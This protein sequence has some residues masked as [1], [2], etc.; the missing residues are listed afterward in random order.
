MVKHQASGSKDPCPECLQF[1]I[2]EYSLDYEVHTYPKP[3]VVWAHGIVMGG[4]IGL[5][6]GASHRIV[7]E[8]SKLAMPEITIGLYPDVGATWFFNK[9]PPGWG[10]FLAMTAARING[11]DSVT[12]GLADYLI[13]SDHKEH[14]FKKLTS[15]QWTQEARANS[16]IVTTILAELSKDSPAQSSV[17]EELGQKIAIFD[18][19]DSINEFKNCLD[20][21]P[22][23]PFILEARNI[24][25]HGSPSSAGI[26]LEQLKRG[27][28]LSLKEVFQSEFNLSIHCTLKPDFAEGVRALLI[29]KDQKPK[30]QP[31]TH[32]EV[33]REWIESH[34]TSLSLSLLF[35]NI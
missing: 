18:K 25:E 3:I 26:I 12:L 1:F 8:K 32:A 33:T 14:I 19:V 6:N 35:K 31:A 20:K 13:A 27:K 23:T 7:T 28:N 21:L 30:W 9:L 34:F 11:R 15:Q 29:D 22:Q 16:A 4:A 17:V 10:E 24:F 5:M 2:S